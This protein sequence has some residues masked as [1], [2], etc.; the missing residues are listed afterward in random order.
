MTEYY[1]T[2]DVLM[3]L[4]RR[5]IYRVRPLPAGWTVDQDPQGITLYVDRKPA[6]H[7][8]LCKREDFGQNRLALSFS[9]M[10]SEL[11]G[12]AFEVLVSRLA[13]A[14]DEVPSRY[15]LYVRFGSSEHVQ[16]ITASHMGFIPYLGEWNE[17]TADDS[18]SDW[19]MITEDL[20][21][22]YPNGYCPAPAI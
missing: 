17:R 21:R 6:A 20:R 11:S 22:V 7:A 19:E 8:R 5:S 4:P 1:R 9:C 13:L 16:I 18:E 10:D 15:P 12:P 3:V 2:Q 14:F